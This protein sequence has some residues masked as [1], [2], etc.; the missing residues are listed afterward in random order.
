[1]LSSKHTEFGM[2]RT[3]VETSFSIKQRRM[4]DLGSG[5]IRRAIDSVATAMTQIVSR[6]ST[7]INIQSRR[8]NFRSLSTIAP[9]DAVACLEPAH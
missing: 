1:M 6:L 2:P 7:G 8:C 4:D 3:P 9:A 5:N